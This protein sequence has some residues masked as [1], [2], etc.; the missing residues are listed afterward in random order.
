M[1]ADLKLR[2][3]TAADLPL[4][5]Q[6]NRKLIRDERADNP[7]SVL[8]LEER[9]RGWLDGEYRAVLFERDEAPVAYALSG[10]TSTVCTCGS[11]SSSPRIDAR[12][13]AALRWT[14]LSSRCLQRASA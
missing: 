7:M 9:M 10:P 2:F 6:M 3:A 8:Q 12:V 1:A 11:S 13:S 14:F 4:L 5:A